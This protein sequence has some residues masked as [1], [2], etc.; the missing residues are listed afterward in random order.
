MILFADG[1]RINIYLKEDRHLCG[2][3]HPYFDPCSETCQVLSPNLGG[4]KA[5]YGRFKLL[6]ISFDFILDVSILQRNE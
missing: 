2:I 3:S 4:L 6:K 5:V 1:L